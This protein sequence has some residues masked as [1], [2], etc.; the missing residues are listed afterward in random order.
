MALLELFNPV[1]LALTILGAGSLCVSKEPSTSID[2]KQH[3]C[4]V[5]DQLSPLTYRALIS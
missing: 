4:A 3:V 2:C 1:R 5:T